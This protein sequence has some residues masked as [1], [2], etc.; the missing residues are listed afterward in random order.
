MKRYLLILLAVVALL[1]VGLAIG[2][3]V[4]LH[5]DKVRDD[6]AVRLGALYGGRVAVGEADIGVIGDT[7]L[8]NLRLYEKGEAGKTPWVTVGSVKTDVSALDLAR[9]VKPKDITLVEP[10]VTLRVDRDG[11][12]LTRLPETGRGGAALPSVHIERGRVTVSRE[13][14]PDLVLSGVRADLMPEGKRLAVTGTISDSFW[15]DWSLDGTIDRSAGTL[16]VTLKTDQADVTQEKLLRIPEVPAVVWNEVEASGRTPVTFTFRHDPA[17]KRM[18]HY[19]VEIHP[20]GA[21]LRLP[22][23]AVTTTD[24]RGG[25]VIEDELVT[26]TKATGKALGGELTVDGTL[27]FR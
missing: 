17:A 18:S 24:V 16:S 10:V 26:I 6:V 19:R 2:A 21:T 15:G 9:G 8:R 20:D 27:D 13:G 23:L 1:A 4:Y 14:H 3:R 22:S 7:T 11:R 5:S 12:L 25:A